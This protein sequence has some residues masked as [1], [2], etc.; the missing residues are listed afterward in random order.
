MHDYSLALSQFLR[1]HPLTEIS[2]A[3]SIPLESLETYAKQH[4]WISLSRELAQYYNTALTPTKGQWATEVLEHNRKFN[5]T[6]ATELRQLAQNVID[7]EVRRHSVNPEAAMTPKNLRDLAAALATIHDLGYRAIGDMVGK[8]DAAQGDK[9]AGT[10]IHVHLPAILA[11]PRPL[12][13]V[14]EIEAKAD[15]AGK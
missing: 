5:Y 8:K 4:A 11:E 13:K 3:M 1:G 9:P 2:S 12:T 15:E 14:I 6:Q 7:A 10:T